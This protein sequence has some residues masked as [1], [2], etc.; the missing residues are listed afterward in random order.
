MTI[1][2][3]NRLTEDQLRKIRELE[4]VCTEADGADSRIS[5]DNGINFVY[6]MDSF[7][8]LY[9]GDALQGLISVFAPMQDVAEISACVHPAHRGQGIFG[10][11]LAAA[12]ASLQGHGYNRLLLVHEASMQAGK[13][14]AQKWGLKIEHSEYLLY[15]SGGIQTPEKDVLEVRYAQESDISEMVRLS[16]ETFGE[17]IE[18]AQHILESAFRDA[19]RHNFVAIA[20]GA[21]VGLG[22]VNTS[23]SSLYV[24]GLGISP[25]HQNKGLGRIMLA[26][27]ISEL[28]KKY[29]R[30]IVLEVD[31]ENARAFH[32][33][34]T[35]GFEV[36]TQ[37]DYYEARTVDYIAQPQD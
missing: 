15:Y 11:L 28:Q 34:T 12:S 29:S 2:Q 20:D 19:S 5:L 22:G 10:Q 4:R 24:F 8:L 33:Y 17:T 13:A 7:F 35:A 31:S 32:L 14:I 25:Q 37:Y 3:T 21:L 36:R 18:E 23:D 26:Q 9:E 16:S 1:L 6:G 27:I 30:E